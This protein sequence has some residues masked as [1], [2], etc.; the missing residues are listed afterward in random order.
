[1][2]TFHKKGMTFT[3][4]HK[5]SPKGMRIECIKY[6]KGFRNLWERISLEEYNKA[7]EDGIVI[8]IK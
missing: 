6:V 7:K 8:P 3:Q 2:S 1:M 5:P 4:Y